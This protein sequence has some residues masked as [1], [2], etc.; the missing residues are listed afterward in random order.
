MS[1][2]PQPISSRPKVV[3]YGPTRHRVIDSVPNLVEHSD[4]PDTDQQPRHVG[5]LGGPALASTKNHVLSHHGRD[6]EAVL[7]GPEFSSEADP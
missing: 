6:T 5:H 4:R 2:T 3:A 1:S 7:C